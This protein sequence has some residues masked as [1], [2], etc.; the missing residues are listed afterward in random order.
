MCVKNN[1]IICVERASTLPASKQSAAKSWHLR[2][3]RYTLEQYASQ[4]Q[5]INCASGGHYKNTAFVHYPES[6]AGTVGNLALKKFFVVG[7]RLRQK[8]HG[9]YLLAS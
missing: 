8:A 7:L 3:L 2:P 4:T 9:F 5:Q 1:A 6:V